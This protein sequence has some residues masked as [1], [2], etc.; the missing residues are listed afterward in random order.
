MGRL[1]MRVGWVIAGVLLGAFAGLRVPEFL[2]RT[3]QLD[4]EGFLFLQILALPFGMGIGAARGALLGG[5]RM[6]TP[7]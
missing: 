3:R 6:R 5:I 7:R 2:L 4:P 1:G